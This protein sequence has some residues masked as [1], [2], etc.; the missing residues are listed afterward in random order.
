MKKYLLN[1]FKENNFNIENQKIVIAVS[2]GIDS[3]ALL[4]SFLEIREDKN[5]DI[6]V[7][8]V[9]HN[10]R[11][12]SILEEAFIKDFCLKNGL[13]CYTKSLKFTNV[14]NFQAVARSYRYDFFYE[15]MEKEGCNILCLAHHGDDL[16]ETIIMRILR[17]SSL[18]GYSAMKH[19]T[20][21]RDMYVIR[22][23]L[24]LERKDI[25]EY[26]ART[27]FFYYEDESNSH[28]DYT[29][30]KIRHLVL[31]NLKEIESG[32]VKKFLEFSNQVNDASLEIDR[33]RDNFIKEKIKIE[34]NGFSFDKDEFMCLSLYMQKEVLF[35][36]LKKHKFSSKNILEFI[37]WIN[38]SKKNFK[39]KYKGIVFLKEYNKISFLSCIDEAIDIDIEIT[40]LGRYVVND[41]ICINV[42][43]KKDNFVTKSNELC[44][45]MQELPIHIRS[46]K[47][48]DKII[49]GKGKQT[50]KIKDLLIDSKVT[51]SRR[52]NILLAVDKD[53]NVLIVF[54]VKKSSILS[55]IEDCNIIIRVEE[56]YA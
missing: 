17:G 41:S 11:E 33:V 44:Y 52:E 47:P 19:I 5:L 18:E 21:V 48:G 4:H 26:Q 6:I 1:F 22:P 14:D 43:E 16:V 30:N 15:V 28:L 2:T 32:C 27:N 54:G 53:D 31:P 51:L 24:D 50:K 45:N 20:K 35:E 8:H 46:R 55:P 34:N 36:M 10:R 9:N 29:R 42:L 39:N 23:F 38:S 49:V 56:N 25:K 7:C 40:K 37:K 13:K 3:M 12:Q